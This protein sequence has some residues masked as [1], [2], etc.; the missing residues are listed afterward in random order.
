M[1]KFDSIK[2]SKLKK[3]GH[4]CSITQEIIEIYRYSSFFE[5]FMKTN[6]MKEL[7]EYLQE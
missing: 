5:C 6:F 4:S 3:Q 7:Q 2:T 1:K